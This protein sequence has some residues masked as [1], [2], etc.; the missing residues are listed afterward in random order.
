MDPV[1]RSGIARFTDEVGRLWCALAEYYVRLGSF[2]RARDVYE[3]AVGSVH[4]VRDF[5]TVFDA[6]AL[7]EETTLTAKLELGAHAHNPSAI[8]DDTNLR[9]ARL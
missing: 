3:E 9:V 8:D 4:T 1:L 2:E 5:A 6:Y 7:F